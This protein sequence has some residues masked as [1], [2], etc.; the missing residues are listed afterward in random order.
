MKSEP[1]VTF[2]CNGL[3]RHFPYDKIS[4]VNGSKIKGFQR[5]M[6]DGA[7]AIHTSSTTQSP[8]QKE[9]KLR[10]LMREMKSVLVAY[11][12]GV[13]SA[14]LG[15]IATQELGDRATCIMGISPSV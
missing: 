3:R 11:S 1:R 14:Y 6:T 15:L 2:G 8:E 5:E 13:D 12:G 10:R 4:L 9:T 7:H